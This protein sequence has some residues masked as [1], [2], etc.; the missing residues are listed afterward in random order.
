MDV[1]PADNL[2]KIGKICPLAIPK[3]ISTISMH[4][5]SLEKSIDIYSSN[6]LETKYRQRDVQ[7]MDEHTDIQRETIIPHHYMYH[8][9]NYKKLITEPIAG[10]RAL[11]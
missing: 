4:T 5:Q 11:V 3:Q 7:Q 6:H 8:V 10:K 1:G 2:L 9:V